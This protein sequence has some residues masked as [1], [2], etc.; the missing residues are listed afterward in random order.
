MIP[1]PPEVH[2]V[3]EDGMYEYYFNY[4]NDMDV[5]GLVIASNDPRSLKPDH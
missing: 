3:D 4:C 2:Q 1:D 5:R